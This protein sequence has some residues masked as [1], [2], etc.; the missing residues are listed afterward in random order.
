MTAWRFLYKCPFLLYGDSSKVKVTFCILPG[1]TPG[2]QVVPGSV[3][4]GCSQPLQKP[5]GRRERNEEDKMRDWSLN[6]APTRGSVLPRIHRK[7]SV[8]TVETSHFFRREGSNTAMGGHFC[9]SASFLGRPV[10][11]FFSRNVL[12]PR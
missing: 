8:S 3:Y 5:G 11:T 7:G 10:G 12:E 2:Q 6:T 1:C 4:V 9:S